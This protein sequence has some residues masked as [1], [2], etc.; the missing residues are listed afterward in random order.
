MLD[1]YA[2]GSTYKRAL[3]DF[4]LPM[5]RGCCV[6]TLSKSFSQFLP[7]T[8]ASLLYSTLRKCAIKAITIIIVTVEVMVVV[9]VIVVVLL[10]WSTVVVG[11]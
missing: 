4:G 3:Y 6:E 8:D 9:S 10:C 1:L 11:Q 2:K 7:S 5:R